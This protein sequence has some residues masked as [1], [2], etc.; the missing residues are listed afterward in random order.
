[1]QRLKGSDKTTQQL[2]PNLND[3]DFD[4]AGKLMAF[5]A[6][7][8]AVGEMQIFDG[9]RQRWHEYICEYGSLAGLPSHM[10]HCHILKHSI[11]RRLIGALDVGTLQAYM[12]H[13]SG[14]STM[15]YLKADDA[16]AS[17]AALKALSV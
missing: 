6:K 11:A 17:A 14:A 5:I 4:E 16:S 13:K 9:S 2:V 7:I 10:Q 3:S 12:G 8:G 1:V 15:E